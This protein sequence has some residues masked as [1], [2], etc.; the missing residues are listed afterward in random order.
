LFV[1]PPK[2]CHPA[3]GTSE[4]LIRKNLRCSQEAHTL[5]DQ[6]FTGRIRLDVDDIAHLHAR[7]KL[8]KVGVIFP[9][10]THS[11]DSPF[12]KLFTYIFPVPMRTYSI[13]HMVVSLLRLPPP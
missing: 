12:Q 2:P 4:C 10:P 9:P 13:D 7:K 11:S 6:A 5:D 3:K 1:P 8:V